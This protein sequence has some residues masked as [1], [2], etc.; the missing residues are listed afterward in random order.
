MAKV[1]YNNRIINSRDVFRIGEIDKEH[2]EVEL[3][4]GEI[5]VVDQDTAKKLLGAFFD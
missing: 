4:N 5:I 3:R 2:Y 1:E